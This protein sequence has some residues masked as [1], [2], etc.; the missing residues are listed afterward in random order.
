MDKHIVYNELK[1][2]VCDTYNWLQRDVSNEDIDLD[3][4]FLVFFEK[5]NVD[6]NFGL[7]G[8][9]YSYLDIVCDS[10]RHMFNE[11]CVGYSFSK[12]QID[13]KNIITMIEENKIEE[14]EA[15]SILI[16]NLRMV[17]SSS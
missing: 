8:L 11:V 5:C 15:N 4:M 10:K 14:L 16:D 3:N 9:I 7:L 12:A 6:E 17:V 2:I 1:K 13:L